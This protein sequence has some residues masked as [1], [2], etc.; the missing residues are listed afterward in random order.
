[1]ANLSIEVPD[2]VVRGLEGI[3]AAQHKS[4]EQVALE[5]LRT[6]VPAGAEY[7]IGS[8]AAV[9][10]A[11]RAAPHLTAEDVDELEA[12]IAAGR[13]ASREGDLFSDGSD[14]D[15]PS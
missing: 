7:P 14:L 1:M 3:A 15:L 8:P 6:L 9:L 11:M 10:Q 13:L 2:D 4:V 12:A 5:R